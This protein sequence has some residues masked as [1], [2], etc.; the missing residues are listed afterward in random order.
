MPASSPIQERL[1]VLREIGAATDAR[2]KAVRGLD[3]DRK[4]SADVW[5]TIYQPKPPASPVAPPEPGG[6]PKSEEGSDVT[7]REHGASDEA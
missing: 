2:D 7:E 3:L 5:A 4:A 6:E 1:A